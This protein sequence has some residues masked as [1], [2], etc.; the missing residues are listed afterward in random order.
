MTGLDSPTCCSWLLRMKTEQGADKAG[1]GAGDKEQGWSLGPEVL[2]LGVQWGLLWS[3]QANSCSW[4]FMAPVSP[5][6]LWMVWLALR[7]THCPP[8]PNHGMWTFC[9]N[10][11]SHQ[12][13][14]LSVH[15][16]HSHP[17]FVNYLFFISGFA[18]VIRQ[19]RE[20][21]NGNLKSLD[22]SHGFFSL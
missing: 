6:P 14:P 8:A 12:T 4:A 17:L 15:H 2:A 7:P 1:K 11:S 21:K 20:S 5:Y 22:F 3:L 19:S 10:T 9:T 16:L 13:S 18:A